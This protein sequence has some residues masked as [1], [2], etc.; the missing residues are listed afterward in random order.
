MIR[1]ALLMV[2]KKQKK[3]NT[4]RSLGLPCAG[5]TRVWFI[6]GIEGNHRAALRVID[7]CIKTQQ[8]T[9]WKR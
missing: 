5:C 3:H 9:E 7:T 2:K 8:W 6:A 1:T 4:L